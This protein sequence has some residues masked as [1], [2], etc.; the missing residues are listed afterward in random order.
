M[1]KDTSG[2]SQDRAAGGG[3]LHRR[4]LLR[5]G[6][7]AGAAGGLAIEAQASPLTIPDWSQFPGE[8]MSGYGA[9]SAY[10]AH[11]A[12][13][14]L[15]LFPDGI[16]DG[17]G[18]SFTPLEKLAGTITPNG[19]F[20]E[21]HHSGIPDIDPSVHELVIHGHV[22][23]PMAFSIDDLLALPMETHTHF[24][25]C[26]GNSL[27]NSLAEPQQRSA[28]E[29]HGL[30]SNVE[31]TGVRLETLLERVGIN[32][33][34]QWMVAEGADAAKLGRS[35]PVSKA[36]GGDALIAL[37]QNGERLRPE[38][39]Y[40]VRLVVPG[41][42]GSMNI[43][44]LRRIKIIDTAAHTK[45]ETSQYTLLQKDGRARQFTYQ[46]GVKS[47]ITA[48]S[49][50][51]GPAR[52]PGI[53]Q[54]SGLAWSGAG[55]ISR[56]EISADGGTSWTDAAIDGVPQPRAVARFRLAWDWDGGPHLLMSRA[57]DETGAVQPTRTEWYAPYAAGQLFH[58]NS[59]QVW[60]VDPTGGV[61]NVYV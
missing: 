15:Q 45:D 22:R 38:Q 8:A 35:I 54:I 34:A 14:V 2:I 12:R 20:F 29:I 6:L 48:P 39:G 40:P 59:I 26:A 53:Y 32:P 33:D 52:G 58:Q 46:M 4:A 50:G 31:W 57:T 37:Y 42:Q 1:F 13:S 7:G 51:V 16:G 27:F 28:G 44:W 61:S 36:M 47:V 60:R 30:I 41:W 5:M 10:E 3:L 11:V 18:V 19:L 17:A 56:V 43:K 25:E 9:P 49:P 21:R 55:R 24:I 23:Q